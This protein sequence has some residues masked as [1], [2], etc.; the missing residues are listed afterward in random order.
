MPD[1]ASKGFS[2]VRSDPDMN[3]TMKIVCIMTLFMG[4]IRHVSYSI[5]ISSVLPCMEMKR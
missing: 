4:M 3:R 2:Q 5:K 1:E